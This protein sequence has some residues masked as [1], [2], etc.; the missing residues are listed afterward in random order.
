M[1]SDPEDVTSAPEVLTVNEV[2][3]RVWERHI[4]RV[5]WEKRYADL[6][7]RAL[8]ELAPKLKMGP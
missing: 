1:T 8:L 4:E 5:E 6:H 7:L 2:L 3:D